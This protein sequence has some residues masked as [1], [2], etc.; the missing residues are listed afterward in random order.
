MRGWFDLNEDGEA[1]VAAFMAQVGSLPARTAT[2]DPAVLWLKAELLRRWDAERRA[3]IPL[4]VM[5]PVEMAA[6]LAAAAFLLYFSLPY[7][8]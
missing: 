5:Q 2:P 1:V 6:G 3:H 8:L 7:L 4:D